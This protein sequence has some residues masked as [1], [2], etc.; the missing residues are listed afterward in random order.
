MNESFIDKSVVHV[1]VGVV[2]DSNGRLLI[3]RRADSAHQGGLWEFP[4]GK[5]EAK[6]TV[7]QA[8]ARELKEELGICVER[9]QPLLQ[10]SHDYADKTVLLDVFFVD[11]FSG[12]ASGLEQQPVVWILRSQLGDY[13]FPQANKAI[14]KLLIETSEAR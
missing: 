3:A 8:L 6:E 11:Q 5:V 12:Q 1:A 9:A 10:I 14:V 2:E 4:G 7:R 13:A